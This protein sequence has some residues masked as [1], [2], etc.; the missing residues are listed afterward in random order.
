MPFNFDIQPIIN[1]MRDLLVAAYVKDLPAVTTA[2]SGYLADAEKRLADLAEGSL[3]G[4][5]TGAEV[6]TALGEEGANLKN[7]LLSI[8]EIIGADLQD[9]VNKALNVFT[10]QLMDALYAVRN[11]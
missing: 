2:V 11:I 4:E 8:G 5:L 10:G 1:Q 9:L 6:L 7:Q 3:S